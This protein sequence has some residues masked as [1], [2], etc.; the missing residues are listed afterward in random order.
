MTESSPAT[1]KKYGKSAL[2][3]ANFMYILYLMLFPRVVRVACPENTV[4][5]IIPFSTIRP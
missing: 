2:R 4:P 1:L 3:K 5:C